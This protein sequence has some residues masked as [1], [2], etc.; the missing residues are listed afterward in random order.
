MVSARLEISQAI[1]SFSEQHLK[2]RP[3]PSFL[4]RSFVGQG[5]EKTLGAAEVTERLRIGRQPEGL[6]AGQPKVLHRFVRTRGF[7]KVPRQPDCPAFR[8][9][10]IKVL[11][12]FSKGLV[13]VGPFALAE[14]LLEVALDQNVPEAELGE[15]AL[16]DLLQFQF[17]HQAMLT[18]QFAGQPPD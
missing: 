9:V 7:G 6:D 13:K 15:A 12:S 2:L 3:G 14:P 10:S 8:L 4:H 5:R 17:P 11:Q 1:E 18:F 16:A